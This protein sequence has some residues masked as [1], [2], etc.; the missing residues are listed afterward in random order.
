MLSASHPPTAIASDLEAFNA[1]VDL[2]MCGRSILFPV[3]STR[4]GLAATSG[5]HHLWH[6]DCDGFGT[7]ID[8]QAGAK[9]WIIA[10]PKD[11]LH[12]SQTTLFTESYD[13]GTP[14]LDKWDTEAVLLRPGSRL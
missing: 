13:L 14:N 12:F 9:W 5:A 1:T 11:S 6:I 10:R 7:Y 2:P 3:A 8:T 4:W